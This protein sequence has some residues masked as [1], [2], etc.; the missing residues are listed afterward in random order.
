MHVSIL[1]DGKSRLNLRM[2]LLRSSVDRYKHP[3][4]P[5]SGPPIIQSMPIHNRIIYEPFPTL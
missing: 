2:F 5:Q 3:A 1:L 4:V